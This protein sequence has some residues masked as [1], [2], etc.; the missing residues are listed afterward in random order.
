MVRALGHELRSAWRRLRQTP[1]FTA[2]AAITLGLGVG[3]NT[4][5]FSVVDPLLIRQLP[6]RDPG[7]LVLLHSSGTLQT[8]DISEWQAFEKY[9]TDRETLDGVIATSG[10][11]SG[12]ADF[13]IM[14]GGRRETAKGA[15][16]SATYFDV[17][18]VQPHLGQFF[19]AGD[20][21]SG[22]RRVVLGHAA[23]IRIFGADAA[24]VGTP[25]V[26]RGIS[27]L[28]AGIAPR[29]FTGLV[30][31]ASPDFYLP[32]EWL[33]NTDGSWVRVLG[34]LRPDVSVERAR[35]TLEPLF[36]QVAA[37]SALPEIEKQQAMSRLLVTPA[38]RGVSEARDALGTRP[39]ALLAVVALV[40]LI[41]CANVAGLVL[42]RMAGRRHEIAIE[43]ALGATR[44]RLA[45]R[46]LIEGTIIA[47][48]GLAVGLGVAHWI[49][50]LL[51]AWLAGGPS[52]LT[53][54]P[55]LDV[56]V[57][58]FT[59]AV[60]GLTVLICGMLPALS[61]ARTGVVHGLT[62]RH[63]GLA[64][65]ARPSGLRRALVVAQIA[66]SVTLVSGTGLV[67][68]SLVNLKTFDLGF[69]ADRVLAVSLRDRSASR[70][71]GQADV[72]LAEI[73]RGVRAMTGVA[74]AAYG[75]IPPLSGSEIGINVIP[76]ARPSAAP[77]HSLFVPAVR[78]RYFETLGIRLTR[79]EGC[80]D[81]NANRG[82]WVLLNQRLAARLF[83][84]AGA[85]GQQV[86]FV[87]GRRAPMTV[88]GIAADTTYVKVRDE[89][90]NL[91]YVCDIASQMTSVQSRVLFVRSAQ[92]SAS[93]LRGGVRSIVLSADPGVEITRAQTLEQYRA[94]SLH[95]DSL[96]AGLFS[97]FTFIAVLIAAVGLYG[98]LAATVVRQTAE[99]GLRMA[100][101]ADS[102]GVMRFVVTPA[103]TIAATGLA[104]GTALALVT[105]SLLSSVLFGVGRVDPVT[106]AGVAL[107]LAAVC[108]L[109]CVVPIRRALR[110]DPV[111]ALRAE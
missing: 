7:R 61:A 54:T 31:G 13:E 53:L 39:W 98:V 102:R 79:G 29:G 57:L 86:R 72:L 66:A 90:R 67:V 89:P 37:A 9:S 22:H 16:V 48:I 45:G 36:R 3:A 58:R 87:E 92:G 40:L 108:T 21:R 100:L 80:P 94:D 77:V 33:P 23:W 32:I 46:F 8:I 2:L 26:A 10:T 49:S 56:R 12:T 75:A 88:V 27:Y 42:T 83:G 81:A 60:L 106:W 82:P 19:G 105:S 96:V 30:V 107:V 85:L 14:V 17:L 63:A 101:G 51:V 103:V 28:I 62:L 41:A 64:R 59:S 1:G 11:T 52:P 25:I 65:G 78:P 74:D 50:R 24:V 68:H 4:A 99:I 43:L 69:D 47:T 70:P 110:I 55:E 20:I 35:L 73:D 6:V 34:R 91:V 15:I 38:G 18:G 71:A 84:D 104:V 111:V 76:D 109:A 5:V 97:T 93:A 95:P 44:G